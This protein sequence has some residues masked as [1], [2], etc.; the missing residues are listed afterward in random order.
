MDDP[1][2]GLTGEEV[3]RIRAVA[4][5]S[6]TPGLEDLA[7]RPQAGVDDIYPSGLAKVPTRPYASELP[8]RKRGRRA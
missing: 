3:R 7:P 4:E 6:I 5:G 8:K 2:D 1:Y